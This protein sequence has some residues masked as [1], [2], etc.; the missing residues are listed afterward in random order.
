MGSQGCFK[1]LCEFRVVNAINVIISGSLT[2]IPSGQ[3]TISPQQLVTHFVAIA[4]LGR[5]VSW[6]AAPALSGVTFFG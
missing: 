3:K 2:H 1:G 6:K 4:M 5:R